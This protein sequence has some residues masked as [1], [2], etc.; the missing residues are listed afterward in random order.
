[1]IFGKDGAE[2]HAQYIL[3]I[4]QSTMELRWIEAHTFPL[5]GRENFLIFEFIVG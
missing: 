1:M 3:C 2:N 4:H 5:I